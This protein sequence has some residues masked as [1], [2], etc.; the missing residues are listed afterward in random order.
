MYVDPG[1]VT[2]VY[3]VSWDFEQWRIFELAFSHALFPSAHEQCACN[4]DILHN[5]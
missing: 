4:F 3:F 5:S 1:R 2:R